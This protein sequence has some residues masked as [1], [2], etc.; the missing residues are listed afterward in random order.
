[1]HCPGIGS[2][3]SQIDRGRRIRADARCPQ[4]PDFTAE[5]AKANRFFCPL[6]SMKWQLDPARSIVKLDRVGIPILHEHSSWRGKAESIRRGRNATRIQDQ[7]QRASALSQVASG[8]TIGL[9][10]DRRAGA[11][12]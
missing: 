7:L 12:L 1:M 9:S 6:V 4:L 5:G 8:V 3:C 10:D 11:R 2:S